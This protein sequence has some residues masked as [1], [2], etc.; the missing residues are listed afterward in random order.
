LINHFDQPGAHCHFQFEQL[1]LEPSDILY[2]HLCRTLAEE[3]EQSH[4]YRIFPLDF[5]RHRQLHCS[6]YVVCREAVHQISQGTTG[7]SCW[8]VLF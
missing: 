8:Q 5:H 4:F 1:G 3:S 6:D 7:L 2:E